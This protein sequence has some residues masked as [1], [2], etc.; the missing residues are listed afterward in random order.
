MEK[1]HQ[2][3]PTQEENDSD[4]EIESNEE[5]E[6]REDNNEKVRILEDKIKTMAIEH[7]TKLKEIANKLAEKEK[8]FE[9]NR[10]RMEKEDLRKSIEIKKLKEENATILEKLGHLQWDKDKMDAEVK[11]KDKVEKMKKNMKLFN[12]LIGEEKVNSD[13]EMEVVECDEISEVQTLQQNRTKGFTRTNPQESADV[14]RRIENCEK[15]IIHCPQC[16]FITPSERFFNEHLSLVHR[17]PN[18]PFCFLPFRG[19][20]DLRKHC[21]NFHQESKNKLGSSKYKKPCRYFKNGEGI[22]S[23]RNGEECPFDHNIIPFSQRQECYHKQSC[24]FKPYCIFYH[25]EGQSVE[26]WQINSNKVSKI[27]YY[28]QQGLECVRSLCRF[29]YPV[30]RNDQGFHWGQVTEPPINMNP[31]PVNRVPVIV[32]NTSLMNY[33]NQ[34]VKRMSLE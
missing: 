16:D 14:I 9:I 4:M 30:I 23:P 29:Y 5:H 24:K 1:A 12:E 26:N 3:K 18:C 8:L 32:K 2:D 6:N 25:P 27:C 34:S 7:E 17:G 21:N 13:N 19:Y 11:A 31:L 10:K 28:S 15:K 33:L 22:C 20:E